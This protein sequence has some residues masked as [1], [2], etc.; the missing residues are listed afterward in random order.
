MFGGF[1]VMWHGNMLAGVIKDDL[2]VRVGLE[3]Y[4]RLAAEPEAGP[5]TFGERSMKGML[6]VDG[7]SVCDDSRLREW[8]DRAAEFVATLPAKEHPR[9]TSATWGRAIGVPANRPACDQAADRPVHPRSDCQYA[10][11]DSAWAPESRCGTASTMRP[12]RHR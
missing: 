7:A 11:S 6:L 9:H 8:L 4:D 5:M 3:A 10:S 2:M 12:G 1:G